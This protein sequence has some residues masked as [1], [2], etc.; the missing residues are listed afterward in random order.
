MNSIGR[1]VF[2]DA[3]IFSV[4][5]YF[6]EIFIFKKQINFIMANNDDDDGFIKF[7]ITD[8]DLEFGQGNHRSKRMTKNQAIY[9]MVLFENCNLYFPHLFY[10]FFLKKTKEY[11]LKVKAM[12]MME[13]KNNEKNVP[14]IHLRL[15]LSKVIKNF[16]MKSKIENHH[17]RKRMN[18]QD[19]HIR[20]RNQLDSVD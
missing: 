20:K 13:I 10:F 3:C 19:K 11:G 9:G 6:V 1:S 8:Q 15:V 16:K 7:E 4:L 14:I 2:F 17:H 5:F 12:M 18:L